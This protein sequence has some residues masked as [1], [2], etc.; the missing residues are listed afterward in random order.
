MSAKPRPNPREIEFE[1]LPAVLQ[2]LLREAMDGEELII[3][4]SRRP[5]AKLIP[6]PQEA[7]PT[8]GSARGMIMMRDDFDAP[9]EDFQEYT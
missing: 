4:Q 3:L 1:Q 9:L 5:I 7:R 8:F 2:S 6:L